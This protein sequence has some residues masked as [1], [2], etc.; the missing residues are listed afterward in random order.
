[1]SRRGLS[2][3]SGA[4]GI[5]AVSVGAQSQFQ[6]IG[7]PDH[8]VVVRTAAATVKVTAKRGAFFGVAYLR[9]KLCQ[10]FVFGLTIHCIITRCKRVA[11]H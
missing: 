9:C 6:T 3:L 8:P 2:A 11:S 4:F 1:M 7:M 10:N 5:L